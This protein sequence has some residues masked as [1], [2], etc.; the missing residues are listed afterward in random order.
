M[1]HH[2]NLVK[3]KGHFTN[4]ERK[5]KSIDDMLSILSFLAINHTET[6]RPMSSIT[7]YDIIFIASNIVTSTNDDAKIN[8][9]RCS[10]QRVVTARHS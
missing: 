3:K 8:A 6:A 7:Y 9:F 4:S 5:I 2:W 10:S 1:C